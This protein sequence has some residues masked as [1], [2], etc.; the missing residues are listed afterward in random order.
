MLIIFF[1]RAYSVPTNGE[2]REN[3]I[4]AVEERGKQPFDYS[5]IRYFICQL[6][7]DPESIRGYNQTA[8]FKAEV[9]PSVFPDARRYMYNICIVYMYI[10][11]TQ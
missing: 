1:D 11:I 3:W 8:K 6:H 5:S 4:K 2:M 10:Y 9:A 7:F